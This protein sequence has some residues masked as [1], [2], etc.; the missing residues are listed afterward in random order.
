MLPK[1]SAYVKMYDGE[2][3]WMQ[4][5]IEDDELLE[6]YNDIWYNFSNSFEKLFDGEVVY[7]KKISE[8]QY[9]MFGWWDYRFSWWRSK[10]LK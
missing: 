10:C 9:K 7:N 6:K 1:M 3:K 8:N 2:T 5:S 4:L